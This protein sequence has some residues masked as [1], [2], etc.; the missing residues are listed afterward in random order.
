MLVSRRMGWNKP[1]RRTRTGVRTSG[2][3]RAVVA[4]FARAFNAGDVK[5]VA[6]LFS[7]D[8]RLVMLNGRA[9]SGRTEIEQLFASSFEAYPGQKIE[10]KTESLRL[11]G[12]DAAI[13][14][15]TA[16]I[17][18]ARAAGDSRGSGETNR[19]TVAYIKRDGRWLQDSVR[20]YPLAESAAE[21]TAHER[22]Q[23]LE[24][25][26]GDWVDESDEAE[27]HTTCR[28]S[29]NQSFLLRRFRSGSGGKPRSQARSGSA[30]IPG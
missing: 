16:T 17:T 28:W 24:W 15:G 18:S 26:V 5:A 23:E 20:D 9:V 1:A 30:G 12:A 4:E 14:E 6:G 10:I 2:L 22:L 3:W 7:S 25:L 8:A 19:Y 27:V 29:E 11:L 21:P 13:E